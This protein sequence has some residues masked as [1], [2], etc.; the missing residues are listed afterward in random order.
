[1]KILKSHVIALFCFAL[2][3]LHAETNEIKKTKPA[4]IK[5]ITQQELVQAALDG[6]TSPIETALKQGYSVDKPDTEKR[7]LLMYAA[8]NG[9]TNV[10]QLLIT[11]GA[12]A[13]ATDKTGST[14]LMFAAS[15]KNLPAVK[16]LLKNKAKI[17]TID[18]N[19]HWTPLMWAAAEGQ[20]DVVNYLLEK[21]ANPLLKDIDGDTAESF[22][23]KK[24]HYTVVRMIRSHL[25]SKNKEPEKLVEKSSLF[26][27]KTSIQK[28]PA[29][30]E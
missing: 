9:H 1:M 23:T 17:N 10:I 22:A 8:F 3:T 20:V 12:N 7:T 4:E 15:G 29:P 27:S 30:A 2:T 26:G 18:S 21:G 11:A 24:K 25:A 16:L 5:K 14:A 19:E 6:K 13:N 28:N